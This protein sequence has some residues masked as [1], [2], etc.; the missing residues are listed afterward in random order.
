MNRHLCFAADPPAN[1]QLTV[2]E[3][4]PRSDTVWHSHSWLCG[5]R[6]PLSPPLPCHPERSEGSAF[7]QPSQILVSSFCLLVSLLP[8]LSF[9]ISS[10]CLL[11]CTCIPPAC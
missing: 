1:L 11:V 6:C 5:V 9:P 3:C 8:P 7:S 4:N 2:P 10:F